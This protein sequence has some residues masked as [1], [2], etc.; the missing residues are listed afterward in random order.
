[1]I[2]YLLDEEHQ[3]LRDTVGEFAREV[4]Q[5]VIGGY[6][7][8][9]EFPY[10]LIARMAKLGLFG[11]P[12]PA[13]TAGWMATCSRWAWRWRNWPGWTPRWPSPWRPR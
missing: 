3:A 7:E 6:Y 5:P 10:D 11:L 9:A 8:R 13:S 4:V 2:N 1:M 12:F